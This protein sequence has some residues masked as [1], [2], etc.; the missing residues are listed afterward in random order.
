MR[1]GVIGPIWLDIPPK[2]YGGTEEVVYNLVNG[3]AE[4]GHDVTLF[5]PKTSKTKAKL[6]PTIDIPLREQNI[7]WTNSSATFYHITEAFDQANKFDIIH[8]HLN[9]DPDYIALPLSTFSK[10]PILFTL[11]FKPPA[12]S[13]NTGGYRFLKKYGSL[14]FTSISNSQAKSIPLNFIKTIYNGLDIKSFPFQKTPEDYFVWF[15]K[16]NP[17]KGTKEAILAAK[18]ANVKLIM[19]GVVDYDMP[20]LATYFEKDVKPLIDGKQ[21][22]WLGEV[23]MKKKIEVISHAKAFLN[24]ILWEE[25]FGLVMAEAQ[26]TGTP[27]ISFN[28]GAAP[29]VV[30]NE[31]TGFLVNT[32]DEMVA[33][34]PLINSIDRH[35]CR[36][37]VENHFST[38]AMV[39]GYEEAYSLVMQ[40]WT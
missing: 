40:K 2:G 34:I 10:T 32:I 21:I 24:P 37:N 7:P 14:T 26:V 23:D 36:A 25:P 30:K 9:K 33:K 35:A 12:S 5:G 20:V 29:E 22:I 8:M 6:I 1:V 27:V 19:L 18:K 11:H 16:V 31:K 39:K 4:K 15:G 17:L 13:D 28:R 3:L 38:E